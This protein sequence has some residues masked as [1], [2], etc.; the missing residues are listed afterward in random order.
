MTRGKRLITISVIMAW[1]VCTAC[2]EPEKRGL[3]LSL[4][5]ALSGRTPIADAGADQM[6]NI[7]AGSVALDGSGS[8]DPEGRNLSYSW[9]IVY[10]PAGSAVS[11]S[12]H[13]TS[14][15]TFL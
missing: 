12:N 7:L 6:V 11:F 8:Y 14:N 10:Q 4:S 1:C 13:D 5:Q 3:L 2:Y 9:R 15:T